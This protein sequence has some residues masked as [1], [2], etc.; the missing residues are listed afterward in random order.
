MFL[1]FSILVYGIYFISC[2]F[3]VFLSTRYVINTVCTLIVL[4]LQYF[5]LQNK[6]IFYKLLLFIDEE[7]IWL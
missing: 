1:P 4:L 2:I 5:L 7:S 3:V 6:L